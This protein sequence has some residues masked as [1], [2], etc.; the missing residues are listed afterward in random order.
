MVSGRE[1]TF[2]VRCTST[3]G[4]TLSM[5]VDGPGYSGEGPGGQMTVEPVGVPLGEG[6]DTYTATTSTISGGSDRDVYQCT[7]YNGVYSD[8]TNT[9]GLRGTSKIMLVVIHFRLE[10]FSSTVASDPLLI[11]LIQTSATSVTVEWSQPSGGATVTG[12]VVH[13]RYGATNMTQSV[14]PSYTTAN[15]GD[16]QMGTLYTFSV[17]ATSEHLSGESG[18][19]T[20]TLSGNVCVSTSQNSIYFTTEIQISLILLL[21]WSVTV[22]HWNQQY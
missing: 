16:L 2:K 6:N 15:I 8:P 18:N 21:L 19:C 13:Y 1:G 11:S 14:P 20:I 12:Y 22:S 17:E 7:A 4:R 9:V 10:S 5:T 3:G